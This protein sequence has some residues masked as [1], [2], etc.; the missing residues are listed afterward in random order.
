[1]VRNFFISIASAALFAGCAGGEVV[2]NSPNA[3]NTSN[4]AV[5]ANAA[6]TSSNAVAPQE[7]PDMLARGKQL[8]NTTCANCHKEDGTGGP[9]EIEGKKIKAENL[10]SDK[11]KNWPDD[12]YFKVISEGIEDEGMPAFGDRL[13]DEEIRSVISYVRAGLQKKEVS[14]PTN[15]NR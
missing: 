7:T 4:T 9:K 5:V 6:N 15:A 8:Y 2:R 11:M 3:A 1:M 13:S 12:R 10:V 14:A